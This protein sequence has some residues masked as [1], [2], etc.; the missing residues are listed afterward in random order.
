MQTK[1]LHKA[2]LA[3]EL[4]I[5]FMLAGEAYMT[6]KSLKTD[7]QFTFKIV[8]Q[9]KAPNKFYCY[10]LTGPNNMNDYTYFGTIY[11]GMIP[12]FYFS[13]KSDLN[14]ATLSVR[15]FEYVFEN[16]KKGVHIKDLEIWHMG[17]CAKCG[18]PLTDAESI[19]IGLGPICRTKK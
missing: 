6:F 9:E 17:L 10:V 15:S 5:P 18:R 13:D 4:V 12:Q 14:K 19:R 11:A 16:L 7:K 2:A 3:Q 1:Y 8:K